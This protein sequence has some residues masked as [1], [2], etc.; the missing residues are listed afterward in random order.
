MSLT[1]GRLS[2]R[3]ILTLS[4]LLA[5]ATGGADTYIL[6]SRFQDM[7]I[8][9]SFQREISGGSFTILETVS[10][11]KDSATLTS[12][13]LIFNPETGA[14]RLEAISFTDPDV[15]DTAMTA[16]RFDSNDLSSLKSLMSHPSCIAETA[17]G[18][19]ETAIQM[20]NLLLTSM[21]TGFGGQGAERVT[22]DRLSQTFR[23]EPETGCVAGMNI[24][25]S[26]LTVLAADRSTMTVG[27][28]GL[29][30][31]F[32]PDRNVDLSFNMQA[33]NARDGQ[34][35]SLT[36]VDSLS[37][38][39]R[40]DQIPE[41]SSLKTVEALLGSAD[42]AF[43]FDIS[44]LTNRLEDG[45]VLAQGDAMIQASMDRSSLGFSM[46]LAFPQFISLDAEV[47]FSILPV[48]RGPRLS[49]LAGDIPGL[50]LVER[51]ALVNLSLDLH[52]EGVVD[53]LEPVSGL[54]P[55][56]IRDMAGSKLSRLPSEISDPVMVFLSDIF[57]DGASVRM[58]PDAPVSAVQL[59]MAG[60][61]QPSSI[62]PMLGVERV[63]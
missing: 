25:A 44:G 54:T 53:A 32:R 14:V 1:S 6:K 52:D 2:V 59:F 55:E 26:K 24:S 18:M 31:E 39:A 47:E 7:G 62:G 21:S 51:L 23:S 48:T 19:P 57:E 43:S 5:P 10:L 63:E 45:T 33:F 30:A 16:G 15:T 42:A 11:Q 40:A 46:R 28:V 60:L 13:Q 36:A 58:A 29:S 9:L 38:T 37:L 4:A 17:D 8:D 35:G 50:S 22:I 27:E 41:R 34:T 56:M 49:T 20:E 3:A 61:L 12:A